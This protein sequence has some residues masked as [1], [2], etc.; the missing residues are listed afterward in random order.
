MQTRKKS[1]S[2]MGFEL[3]AIKL[4]IADVVLSFILQHPK[5]SQHKNT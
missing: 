5:T 3:S 1:E 2:Q 4:E